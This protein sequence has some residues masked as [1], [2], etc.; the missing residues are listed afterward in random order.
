MTLKQTTIILFFR[1]MRQNL[2]S[3]KMSMT[4]NIA[5]L[6]TNLVGKDITSMEDVTATITIPSTELSI[7]F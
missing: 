7:E 6:M 4:L 5:I 3:R 1:M 2:L